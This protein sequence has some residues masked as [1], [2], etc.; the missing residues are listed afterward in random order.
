MWPKLDNELAC[1]EREE[2]FPSIRFWEEVEESKRVMDVRRVKEGGE[3]PLVEQSRATTS[4]FSFASSS[5]S[6]KTENK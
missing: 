1:R 4:G 5:L 6:P 3:R 2:S